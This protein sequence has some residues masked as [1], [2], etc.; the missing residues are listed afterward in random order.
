MKETRALTSDPVIKVTVTLIEP[1]I[2]IKVEL[3]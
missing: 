1:G 3:R 2:G